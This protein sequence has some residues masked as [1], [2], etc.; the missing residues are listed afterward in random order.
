M[1]D[2]DSEVFGARRFPAQVRAKIADQFVP[3]TRQ[4]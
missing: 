2:V 4:F 3:S 1:I